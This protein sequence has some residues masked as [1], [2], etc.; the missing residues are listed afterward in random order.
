M[1]SVALSVFFIVFCYDLSAQNNP[2]E[3]SL[4]SNNVSDIGRQN[5][6]LLWVATDEGLNVFYDNES[7]VFYS[8]IQ[9]SLSILNSKVDALTITKDD[10]LIAMS[11]DG[12]SVFNS[13]E[14]NFKQIK[15]A[16][17]PVSIV[18]DLLDNKYW[19]ATENSGYYVIDS[20]LNLEAHYTFDPLSPLSISTSKVSNNNEKS[21]IFS[22]SKVFIATDN[23]FNVFNKKLKTFKRYFKGKK[24]KL[25]S[26]KIIGIEE[27][28]DRLLV[29][30]EKELVVF[31]IE[32]SI[33]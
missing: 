20:N 26:N 17:S 4:S 21:I 8:N 25:T 1:K 18:E 10:N 22:E 19:V 9:D 12:L 6:G 5:S 32:T 13:D 23:G 24:S 31:N 3:L 30:S 16:S 15:L 33:T 14:F 28:D 7:H 27:Y 2:V 11:Q 29:A